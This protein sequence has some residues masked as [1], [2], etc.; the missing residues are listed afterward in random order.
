MVK[1]GLEVI[2][3]V[4]NQRIRG[5][6]PYAY[7]DGKGLSTQSFDNTH[8]LHISGEMNDNGGN[9]RICLAGIKMISSV[10]SAFE[11]VTFG[12]DG[13]VELGELGR[14][15]IPMEI[16]I[17]TQGEYISLL[18]RMQSLSN[19]SNIRSNEIFLKGK[20]GYELICDKLQ[21]LGIILSARDFKTLSMLNYLMEDLEIELFTN[22]EKGDFIVQSKFFT[23]MT[24]YSKDN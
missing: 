18:S 23:Y 2:L 12:T 7:V 17:H 5:A 20:S 1:K 16:D 6:T 21:D 24:K 19:M 15:D 9:K 8:F 4:W 14:D 10:A 11:Y 3:N 13:V 22:A